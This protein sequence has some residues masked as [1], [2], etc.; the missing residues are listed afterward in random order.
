MNNR[1][2]DQKSSVVS[3]KAVHTTTKVQRKPHTSIPKGS[4]LEGLIMSR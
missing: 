4:I 1:T 2:L 3:D